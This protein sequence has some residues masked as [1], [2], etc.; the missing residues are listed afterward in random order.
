[1]E[2]NDE[3]SIYEMIITAKN[4]YISK[5]SNHPNAILMGQR[6][7]SELVHS[8]ATLVKDE[9]GFSH[10]NNFLIIAGMTIFPIMIPTFE[11]VG[12]IY[13]NDIVKDSD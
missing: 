13:Y 6:Q 1:M 3:L 11:P 9:I 12:F 10:E 7:Y 4:N 5:T 2:R 8:L